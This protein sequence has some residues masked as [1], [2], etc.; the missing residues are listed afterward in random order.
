MPEFREVLTLA[1]QGK[2][3]VFVGDGGCGKTYMLR[4]LFYNIP[5]TCITATTG[6]AALNICLK[7]TTLHSWAGVGLAVGTKE[8]V[9]SEV[10]KKDQAIKR[11]RYT[12]TLIIDE[13]S[14]LG[15]EF[16]E[17]LDFIGKILR[18]DDSRPFGGLQ[19]ICSGDFLQLP[20]VKDDFV[21]ESEIWKQC[22]FVPIKFKEPKRF[23]DL[24]WFGCL[25]RIRIGEI[26]DEDD[27]LLRERLRYWN[28][29]KNEILKK[30]V[31]PTILFSKRVAVNSYNRKQLD[32]IKEEEV[33]F[34][35]DDHV[36]YKKSKRVP[37]KID[38]FKGMLEDQIPEKICLKV[39]AQVMVRFNFPNDPELV[40]G[41]RGVVTEIHD[42]CVYIKLRN[43]KEKCITFIVFETHVGDLIVTRDQ[44]PLT[45]AWATTI[46]KSQGL[47]L[48]YALCNIGSEIFTEGQSYV[49]LSRVRSID[50]LL[51]TAYERDKIFANERARR[52]EE[53][54]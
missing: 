8:E 51:L 37:P 54:I 11:W 53:S 48:D 33:E 39:G 34:V 3:I 23:E 50:G 14:M 46:H 47:T 42:E 5:K 6:I 17:K 4:E 36:G 52:Y 19:L 30:D 22:N 1:T 35:A 27:E 7:A 29:N 43:G 16:F 32:K 21:F 18:N 31:K 13:M 41:T 28:E 25:S 45:L 26:T 12:Q 10:M 2:N 44:I 9:L 49:A 20:P 38:R 40:N 24:K 15:R